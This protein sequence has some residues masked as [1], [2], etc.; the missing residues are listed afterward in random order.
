MVPSNDGQN[1]KDS[2]LSIDDGGNVLMDL[3]TV[4]KMT[5]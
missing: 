1:N 3:A 4:G 5:G 2:E